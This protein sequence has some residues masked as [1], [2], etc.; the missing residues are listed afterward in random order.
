MKVEALE[1][2]VRGPAWALLNET[3]RNL[4]VQSVFGGGGHDRVGDIWVRMMVSLLPRTGTR[5]IEVSCVSSESRFP[6]G[7]PT[8]ISGFERKGVE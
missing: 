4:E 3:Y 6:F 7:R 1:E 5:P 8:Q 2:P